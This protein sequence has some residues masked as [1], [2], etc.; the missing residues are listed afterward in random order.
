MSTL[1]NISLIIIASLFT[2]LLVAQ[3]MQTLEPLYGI[4]FSEKYLAIKVK[5]NG[6]TRAGNFQI[7]TQEGETGIHL[8]IVREKIDQCR[9]MPHIVDLN[10]AFNIERDKQYYIENPMKFRKTSPRSR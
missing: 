6:C 8:S 3:T 1:K 4:Q 9:A 5:S 7:E 2:T 10:L